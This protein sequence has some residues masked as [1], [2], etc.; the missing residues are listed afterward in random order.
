MYFPDCIVI[1]FDEMGASAGA[2]KQIYIY[3]WAYELVDT[4]KLPVSGI[5]FHQTLIAETADRLIFTNDFTYRVPKYYIEK[6]ELGTGNAKVYS[7][8][9]PDLTADFEY[10]ED[11]EW[12]NNG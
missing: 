1:G 7:Y 3:N 4:I 12:L 2:D 8:K 9:L 5:P 11:Q 10:W 6:S